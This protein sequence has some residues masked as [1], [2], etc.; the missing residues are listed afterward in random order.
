VAIADG[1][2]KVRIAGACVDRLNA[3]IGDSIYTTFL[4]SQFCCGV[5]ETGQLRQGMPKETK[6]M[7]DPRGQCRTTVVKFTRLTLLTLIQTLSSDQALSAPQARGGPPR[8]QKEHRF[9]QGVSLMNTKPLRILALIATACCGV[10]SARG[11]H[12]Q[13]T[14][15][16][17]LPSSGLEQIQ[18]AP[19]AGVP[20]H[21]AAY[22]QPPVISGGMAA[23]MA[24]AV[25][26]GI[27]PTMAPGAYM[28]YQGAGYGEPM[29][30]SYPASGPIY[31]SPGVGGY[32]DY[33]GGD[34]AYGGVCED[35]CLFYT[36]AEVFVLTRDAKVGGPFT[37][38]R[39]GGPTV[40]D[41]DDLE[42]EYEPGIRGVVGV[43]LSECLTLEASYFGLHEYDDTQSAVDPAGNL[44]S[45]YSNFGTG[46]GFIVNGRN[47]F[48]FTEG[49]NIQSIT[50]SSELHNAELNL[51]HRFPMR[52]CKQELWLFAG[53]RYIKVDEEFQFTTEAQTN[54]PAL[55]IRSSLSTVDTDNDLV[56]F[57]LGGVVNHFITGRVRVSAD[58]RSG[59]MVNFNEQRSEVS[60]N[61]FS[62]GGDQIRDE[63]LALVADAGV[64]LTWDITCWLSLTGGYRV[65]YLDGIAL[66]PNNF[67]PVLPGSGLRTPFLDNDGSIL[68]HGATAGLEVRW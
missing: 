53:A 54:D 57:Q 49:S 25:G 2:G 22:A 6:S 64:S 9:E 17:A 46:T 43:P 10:S 4:F 41:A 3:G 47:I 51:M 40:L 29:P 11:Q 33:G 7:I 65:M 24:P 68:F 48:D 8:E 34:I 45:V 28:G 36:K 5:C 61:L 12:Y 20:V 16:A 15:V 55:R 23:G 50:Y 18:T 56:G 19:G 66:A 67:N 30:G 44:F 63:T 59:L 58:A 31:D 39:V 35:F 42:F 37:S 60:T 32:D 62:L 21:Q 26:A 52:H 14:P 27:A 38:L 1:G 13:P